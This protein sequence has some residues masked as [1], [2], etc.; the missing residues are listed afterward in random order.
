MGP[1]E[2]DEAV[3]ANQ[4]GS[5]ERVGVDEVDLIGVFGLG[6][7]AQWN[8]QLQEGRWYLLHSSYIYYTQWKVVCE[9]FCL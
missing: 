3:V 1:G 8:N 9:K 7:Q 2:R 6:C 5:V 4:P